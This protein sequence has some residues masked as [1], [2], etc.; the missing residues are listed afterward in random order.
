[1]QVLHHGTAGKSPVALDRFQDIKQFGGP[2]A[3]AL[4]AFAGRLGFEQ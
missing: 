1:V 4:G 2:V 3:Q